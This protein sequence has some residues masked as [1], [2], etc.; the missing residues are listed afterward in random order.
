MNANVPS[1]MLGT[2]WPNNGEIDIIEGVNTQTSNSMTLHTS[3]GC[4]INDNGFTGT[5][6]TGNC[7]IDAA[8][9]PINA[10]CGIS[11]PDIYSYGSGFNF[12]RGGVY[13][14]EWTS[15]GI[16]IWFFPRDSIPLDIIA[17]IPDPMLWGL[18]AAKFAGG[19][20]IN[21]HFD[22]MSIVSV[23]L[24]LPFLFLLTS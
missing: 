20:D 16:N 7:Y 10:G 14:T 5:L 15:T 3:D 2:S 11:N 24:F 19:C 4:T 12:I 6:S 13:A 21:E 18:P 23:T 9:Q 1:W 17:G 8:G 22:E